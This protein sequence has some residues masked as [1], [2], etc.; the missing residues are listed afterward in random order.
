[1]TI[2]PNLV[3]LA[4]VVG[5]GA[6]WLP[7]SQTLRQR[8]GLLVIFGAASIPGVLAVMAVQQAM[9]GSPMTSGYGDLSAL[10]STSNILPNLT[11]YPRWLIEV[12]TPLI[13]AALAAPFVLARSARPLAAWLLVFVAVTFGLYLPYVVFDA[14]WYLRFLL[15][16]IPPLLALAVGVVMSLLQ[17]TSIDMRV[18][19]FAALC[20]ALPI[21]FVKTAVQRDAFLLW[22]HEAR[23]R[24]GGEF[25][26]TL[27]P[28]AV[29][30]TNH[31]SGSVRFY[32]GR[33]TAG[34]GDITPGRL[35][36]AVAFM[37]GKGLKTYLLFEEWEEADFRRRFGGTAWAASTGRRSPRSTASS[38][39]TIRTTSNG[40][41]AESASTRGRS[42]PAAAEPAHRHSSSMIASRT[43]S[44]TP[45]VVRAGS[46]V[47]RALVLKATT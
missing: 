25:V 41:H 8:L 33:S 40:S 15:P 16:A 19:A 38:A 12:H 46:D 31:Q 24:S 5:L 30:I 47:D 9:F 34:W 18:L 11:R 39:S 29:V 27:P 42:S 17:R 43:A 2:R 23:F 22:R 6:A 37:R 13:A 7:P 14:W 3:P 44:S 20:I 26:A 1:M 4:V 21:T 32:S 10:F 45:R 36:D 35:D 28:N